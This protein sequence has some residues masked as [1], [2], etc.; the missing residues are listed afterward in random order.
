MALGQGVIPIEREINKTKRELDEA[1]WE[2][3]PYMHLQRHLDHL[4]EQLK[5]GESVYVKF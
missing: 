5:D 4:I 2:G 1:E 3:R